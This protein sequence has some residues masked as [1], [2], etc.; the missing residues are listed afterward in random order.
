LPA[1]ASL[2]LVLPQQG[3][4]SLQHSSPF[5]QHSGTMAQQAA[6]LLQQ[7]SAFSQQPSFEAA[8][9]HPLSF[10]QQADFA[11]QQSAGVALVGLLSGRPMITPRVSTR[12][13]NRF[14]NMDNLQV[15]NQGSDSSS[16]TVTNG[17]RGG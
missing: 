10:T 2:L 6:F 8:A 12:A 17:S 14:A 5:L 9:Q 15:W 11:L 3:F 1:L 4:T 16:G 7:V 13:A